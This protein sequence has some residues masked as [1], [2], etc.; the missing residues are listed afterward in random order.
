MRLH[1]KEEECITTL[2]VR[3]KNPKRQKKTGLFSHRKKRNFL[4]WRET[5]GRWLSYEEKV[6]A[7]GEKKRIQF[8]EKEEGPS[9][10]R[11]KKSPSRRKA[12]K[13]EGS[14]PII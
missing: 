13:G 9:S 10:L 3:G 11:K 2:T 5:R 4:I 8:H 1:S 12:E 6:G 14:S 7:E